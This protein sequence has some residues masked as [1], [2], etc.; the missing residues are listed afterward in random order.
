MDLRSGYPIWPVL[1]GLLATWPAL[2]SDEQCDVAVLGGGITGALIADR[3]TTAGISTIVVDEREIGWG[4]TAGSTALLQ[5]ELDRSLGELSRIRGES[6]AVHCYQSCVAALDELDH[7]VRDLGVDVGYQKRRVLYLASRQSDVARLE[8]ERHLRSQHDI[9]VEFWNKATLRRLTG[10]D[11]PGALT[12]SHA[13]QVDPYHLTVALLQRA[14]QL[15]ARVFDRTRVKHTVRT[16]NGLL[17]LH[18]DRGATITCHTLVRATGY[19]TEK[20]LRQK[21]VTLHSTYAFASEPLS[22][23]AA[24][25]PQL[26]EAARPYLYLRTTPDQRLIVGGE[27][28][29]FSNAERRDR[30]LPKKVER[31]VRKAHKLLPDLS[32]EPAYYW[33]GTFAE[34]ADSMPFI[35]PHPKYPQT[36]FALCYGGNGITFATIAANLI[37]NRLLGRPN[38]EEALFRFGR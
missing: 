4:A 21:A 15:G 11:R 38:N 24:D 26:W 9:P 12:S 10:I 3:L 17:A 28:D 29:A 33:A 31:L 7:I 23:L 16:R 36:L 35:G 19:E 18:T 27:D 34:S 14:E 13:A 37:R 2:A 1:D 22:G 32:I 5:Y 25:F 30:A 6:E 20:L 8:Q